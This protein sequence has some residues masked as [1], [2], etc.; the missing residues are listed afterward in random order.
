M[1]SAWLATSRDLPEK[2]EAIVAACTSR[3]CLAGQSFEIG[4]FQDSYF[5]LE[6]W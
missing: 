6:R 1:T 3:D 2:A 4:K 5:G